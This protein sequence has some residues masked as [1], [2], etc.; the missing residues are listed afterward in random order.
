MPAAPQH[1]DG[2]EG[3]TVAIPDTPYDLAHQDLGVE[4]PLHKDSH[5]ENRR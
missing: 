2:A 3:L 4:Q 1:I 5:T